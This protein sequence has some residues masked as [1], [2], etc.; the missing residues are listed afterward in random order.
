MN[1]IEIFKNNFSKEFLKELSM[2]L[3]EDLYG[4]INFSDNNKILKFL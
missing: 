3:K 4:N 1:K 2:I